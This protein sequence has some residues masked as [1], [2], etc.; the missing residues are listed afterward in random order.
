[1][2][3]CSKEN[4]GY[5]IKVRGHLS[6][7]LARAFEELELT[8]SPDGC[9]FISGPDVDQSALFGLL[10]RIRDLGLTLVEVVDLGPKAANSSLKKEERNNEQF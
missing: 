9:T 1:M 8:L 4:H 2:D 7:R 3:G 10:I 6:G 5:R